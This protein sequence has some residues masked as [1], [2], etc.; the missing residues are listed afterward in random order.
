M[1]N[2]ATSHLQRLLWWS[3]KPVYSAWCTIHQ[4]CCSSCYPTTR[5]PGLLWVYSVSQCSYSIQDWFDSWT[6]HGSFLNGN[7]AGCGTSYLK[8]VYA[9]SA[10]MTVLEAAD[11]VAAWTAAPAGTNVEQVQW[12]TWCQCHM[13]ILKW[14][15]QPLKWLLVTGMAVD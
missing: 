6:L 7:F 8:V 2:T 4:F 14:Y 15:L 12:E 13:N 3:P 11:V 9:L 10:N 5:Y 1:A